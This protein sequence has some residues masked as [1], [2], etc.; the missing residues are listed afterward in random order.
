MKSRWILGGSVALVLLGGGVL[1]I[2]KAQSK[3][4]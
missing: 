3:T 4:P 2:P 1:L